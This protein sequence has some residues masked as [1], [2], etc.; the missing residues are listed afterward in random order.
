MLLRV[1]RPAFLLPPAWFLMTL[2]LAVAAEVVVFV[3]VEVSAVVRSTPAA[4]A[5]VA[6]VVITL[7]AVRARATPSLVVPVARVIRA[8]R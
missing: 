6:D 4:F 8:G 5:A 3:A 1:S 2:S 7:P